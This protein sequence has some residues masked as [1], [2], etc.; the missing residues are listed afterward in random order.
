MSIEIFEPSIE[1][2]TDGRQLVTFFLI[3]YNQERFI[4]EALEGAFA[5]TYQPLE[6]VLSDDCSPDRT[7]E[8][9]R[10]VVTE[11]KGPHRVVLSRN[12]RNLGLCGNVNR[13]LDLASGEIVV[14]AAGDDISSPDRVEKSWRILE[15]NPDANCVSFQI[16]TIDGDG[17]QSPNEKTTHGPLEKYS[18]DD[19]IDRN[20]FNHNGASRA[21]R[22]SVYDY[23]GPLSVKAAT[24]DSTTLLRCLMLGAA[25]YSHDL[26]IYYRVHGG[27]YYASDK[28]HSIKYKR[29]Y[30]QYL[31]DIAL[32]LKRGQVSNSDAGCLK[33]V[34]RRRLKENILSTDYYLSD[35][36]VGYFYR[37]I[38]YSKVFGAREKLTYFIRTIKSLMGT[39]K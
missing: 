4:R 11:Y 2:E 37:K 32:A 7:F 35:S 12:E 6:I 31:T 13:V 3:S 38:L 36:K 19:F 22:K 18:L 27:N 16:K 23:F 5:Q 1:P 14:I 21:F 20:G 30:W 17:V 8:I 26:V 10:Q 34:L 29:I 15:E 25:C 33:G 39:L 9:M 24:E 28:K